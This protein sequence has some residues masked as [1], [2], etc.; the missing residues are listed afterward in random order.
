MPSLAIVDASALFAAADTSESGHARCL[1]VLARRDLDLVIPTLVVAEAAYLVGA[2]LGPRPEAAFIRG[3]ADFAIEPPGVAE[4]PIIA[5]MVERYSD[6]RLGT[7]DASVAVLADR[8][9]TDL[10]ITLDRRHFAAVRSP[11]GR[12]F[13]LLPE[14]EGVHEEPAP[15]PARPT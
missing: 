6:L 9:G 1:E 15:Y 2:R 7:T 13:R 4:W 11:L 10:V 12:R 3:L 8:L 14:P 5:D